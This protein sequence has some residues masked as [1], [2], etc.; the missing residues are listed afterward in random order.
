MVMSHQA[1]G[2][3]AYPSQPGFEW[4]VSLTDDDQRTMT[5]AQIVEEYRRGTLDLQD[6][7]VWRDGMDDWLPLGQV[8]ELAMQ[9]GAGAAPAYGAA[10]PAGEEL[11]ST[12]MMADPSAPQPSPAV[13]QAARLGGGPSVDVFDA[14]AVAATGQGG[15]PRR[16][17]PRRVGERNEQSALFSIDAIQAQARERDSKHKQRKGGPLPTDDDLMG[18]G[19]GMGGGLAAS[20]EA[21]SLTAPYVPPPPPPQ[22]KIA[23]D[24]QA[25]LLVAAQLEQPQPKKT[26]MVVAIAAI[27]VVVFG[28]ITLFL[29]MRGGGEQPTASTGGDTTQST[30]HPAPGSDTTVASTAPTE[31]A[32]TTDTGAAATSTSTAGS[33]TGPGT[34]GKTDSKSD[35]K[36]DAKTDTKTDTKPAETA[37]PAAGGAEFNRDAASAAMGG[38]AGAASGCGKEGG[39]TGR[40]KVSVTFAPSG[41]ATNV[42]VGPPFG[43]TSVGSCIAGAFRKI[44]VPPFSGDPITVSKSVNIK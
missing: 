41:R 10:A 4:S 1:G 2:G 34:T 36:T 42:S 11:G 21:P 39:P 3:G 37:A 25:Q 26:G 15:P 13:A 29:V 18:L 32:P 33:K 22:P 44:S 19:S 35:T 31:T 40:G 5:G 17:L 27:V 9:L 8:P 16:A 20:L 23:P 7:F 6:T 38:A 14:Q 24:I 43:G 30:E 12:V 28:A